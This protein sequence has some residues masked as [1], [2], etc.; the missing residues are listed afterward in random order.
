MMQCIEDIYVLNF[1]KTSIFI[2]A[3]DLYLTP[4]AKRAYKIIFFI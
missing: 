1:F 4:L 2:H 3:S